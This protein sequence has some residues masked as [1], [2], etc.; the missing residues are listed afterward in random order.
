M[1]N[2]FI[3]LED[4]IIDVH[5]VPRPNANQFIKD[6]VGLEHK[7][8]IWSDLGIEYARRVH[9]KLGLP[10][11]H[12]FML[13]GGIDRQSIDYVIDCNPTFM[14]RYPGV[15]IP[16]WNSED[17]S[18]DNKNR[19]AIQFSKIVKKVIEEFG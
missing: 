14:K 11:V 6:L 10:E 7:I 18:E 12:G 8:Y 2:I 9:E 1:K 15:C 19:A 17:L 16:E 5:G 4:V 13:R 3:T